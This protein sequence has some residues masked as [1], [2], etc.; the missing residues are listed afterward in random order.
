MTAPAQADTLII[1]WPRWSLAIVCAAHAA[2]LGWAGWTLPWADFSV[3]GAAATALAALHVATAVLAAL[4]VHRPLVHVWRVLSIA[5]MGA[6]AF[7][8]VALLHAAVHIVAVYGSLGEGVAAGLLAAWGLVVLVTV[9]I[10][11]WGLALTWRPRPV[12]RR[13]V[14]ATAAGV[15]A[16]VLG[17]TAAEA[18][19]GVPSEPHDEAQAIH[20]ALVEALANADAGEGVGP[21][22]PSLFHTRPAQCGTPPQGD[23][24][25]V[26]VSHLPARGRHPRHACLQAPSPEALGEE[27][28]RL[29]RGEAQPA[30]LLL[31]VVTSTQVLEGHHP[32]LEALALRP[33][34]D[35]VCLGPRCLAPWQLIALE[36]FT[37]H[38]PLPEVP[39][40]RFG[41]SPADLRGHLGNRDDAQ[42]MAGLTRIATRSYL[43][44]GGGDL[45]PLKRL[46]PWPTD[47]SDEA[48]RAGARLAEHHVAAAQRPGGVFRYL[49]DPFTGKAE[50]QSF[51]MARQ[52]G[53]TLALCELAQ[54][55]G[56]ASRMA[57][58]SLEGMARHERRR[59][60][61]SALAV[62]GDRHRLTSSTLP[63]AAMITC[64]P[65]IGPDFDGLIG[66]LG[67]LVLTVQ[68]PDGSFH[69]EY[70]FDLEMPRGEGRAMFAEG[71]AILALVLLAQLQ[72]REPSPHFPSRERLDAA[73]ERAMDHFAGPYWGHAMRDFFFIAENWH[74]LAARAA[75]P[76]H[77][78]DGYERFCLDYVRFHARLVED[79]LGGPFP[80]LDGGFGIGVVMP[81]HATS[82]AGFGEAQAAAMAVKR[83]RG[84]D[85]TEDEARMRRVLRF[86]LHNQWNAQACVA[87]T[88]GDFVLGGFSEHLASPHIRIDYVQH[89]WAALGHGG[90]ALT[91]GEP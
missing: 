16:L 44:P 71:Q 33:G 22:P 62:P 83:A 32:L 85:T 9:P 63:L 21:A 14:V 46:R 64:R 50:E 51:N 74:C 48:I 73:I 47:A 72:E 67:E 76:S 56:R 78:H 3:F 24:L 2:V 37:A 25:T 57:R 36:A 58:A 54:D 89:A 79:A 6:V 65:L 70:D 27:L 30:P 31:D 34:L 40:A 35:G 75:L 15:T 80:E 45:V 8:G 5:S 19:S 20:E 90:R 82:T 66:R 23:T 38:A 69:P 91:V 55:R 84:M 59:G 61:L 53:T 10:A 87:C 7:A 52:G 81:P 86:L 43:A 29:L 18:A 68:R 1:R 4:A 41:V 77:R 49:L 17:A 13:R 28:H 12:V 88:P 11:G 39:E 60:R 26:L 42:G